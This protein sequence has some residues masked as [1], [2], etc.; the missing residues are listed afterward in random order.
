[1]RLGAGPARAEWP[2]RGPRPGQRGPRQLFPTSL[3]LLGDGDMS[4]RLESSSFFFSAMWMCHNQ[5]VSRFCR[6]F[7]SKIY[8]SRC[9]LWSWCVSV[10]DG[11]YVQTFT[12][13]SPKLGS[14]PWTQPNPS[15]DSSYWNVSPF[16]SNDNILLLSHTFNQV[17]FISL[18]TR[19]LEALVCCSWGGSAGQCRGP[20][21]LC[22]PG[23]Q[24][25]EAGRRRRRKKAVLK[26][27]AEGSIR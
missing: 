25:Q 9:R 17:E 26:T 11:R 16:T 4:N 23:F 3:L 12:G 21:P 1:M 24:C 19:W 10:N 7:L 18:P 8:H 2:G 15:N 22:M 6:N 5:C 14:E 13:K 27:C 20:G